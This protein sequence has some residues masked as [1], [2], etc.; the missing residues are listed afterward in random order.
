MVNTSKIKLS[1]IPT[2]PGVYLFKKRGEVLYV[3]K[4]NNL[5]SR[6]R[7]YFTST[8][9]EKVRELTQEATNIKLHTTASEPEAL[10]TE[11][12]LI[13]KYQPKYNVLFRDDK[14]YFF[15]GFTKE[16][17]PRIF[18]THQLKLKKFKGKASFIGPFTEG[19]ALKSILKSIRR[20]IPFCMCKSLHDKLCL[21]YHIGR[22]VGICCLKPR[23]KNERYNYLDTT[24]TQHH[25][26]KNITYLKTILLGKQK[27]LIHTLE[28]DMSRASQKEDFEQAAQLRDMI[29]NLKNILA[30]KNISFKNEFLDTALL[31]SQIKE[32]F[33]LPNE[34]RRIEAYDISN[35]SGTLAVGTMVVFL[36]TQ[37]DKEEYKKFK[38]KN[39]QGPNDVAMM[40]EM[41]TRRFKH[42]E[43]Q[44]PDLIFIDGGAAQYNIA[45]KTI[46]MFNMAIP[47]ISF[48]KGLENV[49]ASTLQKPTPLH[50]LP[51]RVQNFIIAVKDE[52]HRFSITYHRSLRSKALT[53]KNNAARKKAFT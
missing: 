16:I 36:K 15:V 33:K 41:L 45:R 53:P 32:T 9:P 10:I 28:T 38:I 8:I 44:K 42:H 5:R 25:Y 22:C 30:H 1:C 18:L 40:G 50:K 49:F 37:P 7:S 11:A 31:L 17:Y 19:S 34:P 51:Q 4:A 23:A 20:K 46:K 3:G 12:Y 26:K 21:N 29:E 48:A 13:K 24:R 2:G 14:N 47:I 6:L 27:N 35:I 52:V 43:W 39:I